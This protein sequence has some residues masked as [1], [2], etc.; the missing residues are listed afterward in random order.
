[1]LTCF[2]FCR[3]TRMIDFVCFAAVL[4]RF[5]M[6]F[7]MLKTGSNAAKNGARCFRR[8]CLARALAREN[9]HLIVLLCLCFWFF[10]VLFE[11]I[12][13]IFAPRPS[14]EPC[15]QN[16]GIDYVVFGHDEHANTQACTAQHPADLLRTILLQSIPKQPLWP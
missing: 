3:P 14:C 16:R 9:V 12:I 13:F 7:S 6:M 2:H 11:R 15:R 5:W 10:F 8:F 4:T 1:M